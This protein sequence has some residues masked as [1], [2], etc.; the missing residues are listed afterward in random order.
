MKNGFSKGESFRR[1]VENSLIS[2][3]GV[4]CTYVCG[5][6]CV[7][8]R[9]EMNFRQPAR[10]K[11]A[12]YSNFPARLSSLRRCEC[13]IFIN[14]PTPTLLFQPVSFSRNKN[15]TGKSVPR[16]FT[17]NYRRRTQ[18][19]GWFDLPMWLKVYLK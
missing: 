5:C 14:E 13:A 19:N 4:L 7:F 15:H 17:G 6:V 1:N 12:T 11:Q 18:N 3:K 9:P 2:H 10:A 8:V 16:H